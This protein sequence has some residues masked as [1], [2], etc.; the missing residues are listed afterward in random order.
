MTGRVMFRD[1]DSARGI[2]SVANNKLYILG[3]FD[4]TVASVNQIWE[5]IRLP[6]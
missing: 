3:G 1:N 2:Y 5:F 6:P 4:I